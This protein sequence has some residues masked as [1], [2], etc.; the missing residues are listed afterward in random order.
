MLKDEGGGM[1]EEFE[2][3]RGGAETQR[4]NSSP[5]LCASAVAHPSSFL[6]LLD[7]PAAGAW[8]M[9]VDEALLVNA[10]RERRCWQRF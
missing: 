8:N 3:H 10:A 5:R 6:L 7:P 4:I 1:R 9:A 2:N